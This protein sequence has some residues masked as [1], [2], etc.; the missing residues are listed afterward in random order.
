M[1]LFRLSK[2]KY[3]NSL[4]GFGAAKFGNRWNSKGVEIIYTAES[5]A[6]AMSEV[7]VHLSLAMLPKDF[8]MVTVQIPETTSISN[9]EQNEL[10]QFWNIHP[11]NTATQKVGDNFINEGKFCLLKVPSA[12]VPGDFNFLIN[13]HH[14]EISK[15]SISEIIGF[16]F[17]PRIFK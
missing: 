16:P 2:E 5:R 9:L 8:V 10:P 1:Q 6:L 3:A 4:N 13:P 11:P 17:D 12:V 7:L 15:I 14:S